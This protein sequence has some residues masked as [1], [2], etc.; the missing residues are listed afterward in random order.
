MLPSIISVIYITSLSDSIT[1]FMILSVKHALSHIAPALYI[2]L[3]WLSIRFKDYFQVLI[4]TF[5]TLNDL[6]PG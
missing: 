5:Q 2:E 1:T 3:G 6:G 4:L